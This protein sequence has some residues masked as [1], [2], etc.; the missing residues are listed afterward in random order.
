[1]FWSISFLA[2]QTKIKQTFDRFSSKKLDWMKSGKAKLW[3]ENSVWLYPTPTLMVAINVG[4]RGRL[5]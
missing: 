4:I 2:T 5:S 1:M 3:D